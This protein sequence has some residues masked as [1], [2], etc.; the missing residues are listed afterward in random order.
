MPIGQHPLSFLG[1]LVE[2]RCHHYGAQ[3]KRKFEKTLWRLRTTN[4]AFSARAVARDNGG[5]RY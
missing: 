4:A 3:A 2:A 5:K 1:A